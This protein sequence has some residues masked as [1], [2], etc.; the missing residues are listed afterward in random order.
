MLIV[1]GRS[2]HQ[3]AKSFAHRLIGRDMGGMDRLLRFI[4]VVERAPCLVSLVD[5][6]AV[7]EVGE[8]GE[9]CV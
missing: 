7:G 2:S 8:G 6:G 5:A 1:N 3:F 9:H 4:S